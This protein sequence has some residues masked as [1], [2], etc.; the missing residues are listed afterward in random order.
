MWPFL[1]R[2]RLAPVERVHDSIA[3]LSRRP[4]L[5]TNYGVADSFEGR[6]ELLTLHL[7]LVLRRLAELPEP[8]AEVAQDLTDLAF[9][10]LDQGLREIGVGD[11]GV[12][13]RMKGLAKAFYGR[14]SAYHGAFASRDHAQLVDALRRNVFGEGAGDAEGLAFRIE[15]IERRLASLDLDAMLAAGLDDLVSNDAEGVLG[16]G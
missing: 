12:P 13:R 7:A 16:H 8:G 1:K 10:R 9:R 5:F 11:I 14:A 15:M 4:I 2:N 6:F 3:A